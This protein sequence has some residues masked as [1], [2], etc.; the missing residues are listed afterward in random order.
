ML[1]QPLLRL[2][3]KRHQERIG[4]IAKYAPYL[5]CGFRS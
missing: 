5:L 3:V 1:G 2:L 4:H